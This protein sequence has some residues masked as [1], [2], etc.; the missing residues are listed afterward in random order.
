MG[1]PRGQQ[2]P[3]P[4]AGPYARQVATLERYDAYRNAPASGRGNAARAPRSHW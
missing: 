4:T 1:R 2:R 3:R